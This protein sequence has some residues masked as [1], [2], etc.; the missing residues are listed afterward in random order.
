MAD[1]ENIKQRVSNEEIDEIYSK[2]SSSVLWWQI[3]DAGGGGCML[4]VVDPSKRKV[5]TRYGFRV[6]RF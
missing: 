6:D 5:Y 3:I 2:A 4:L 1:E